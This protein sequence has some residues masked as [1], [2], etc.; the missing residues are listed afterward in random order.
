[1]AQPHLMNAALTNT[2]PKVIIAL[3][4]VGANINEKDPKIGATALMLAASNNKNPEV[5]SA[6]L[7]AGANGKETDNRGLTAMT[8]R[9][10]I[11][12]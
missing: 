3:L 7:K 4:S 2:N 10:I 12:I 9:V 11:K 8:M 5:V 1:M 6:L